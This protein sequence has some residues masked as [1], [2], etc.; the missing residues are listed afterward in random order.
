MEETDEDDDDDEITSGKIICC[1]HDV[2]IGR[3]PLARTT[4][5]LSWTLRPSQLAPRSRTT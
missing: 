3:I 5:P 1:G 2:G 4:L